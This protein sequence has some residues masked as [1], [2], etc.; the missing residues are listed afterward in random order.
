[1]KRLSGGFA[2]WRWFRLWPG[3]QRAAILYRRLIMAAAL[4]EPPFI[5]DRF[6]E[7][8]PAAAVRGHGLIRVGRGARRLRL[9]RRAWSIPGV[10]KAVSYDQNVE[11]LLHLTGGAASTA[12]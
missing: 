5:A 3:V 2:R 11:I 6:G 7:E 9:R 4:H 8:N 10:G 12:V 1:M